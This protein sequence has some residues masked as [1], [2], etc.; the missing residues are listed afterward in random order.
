MNIKKFFSLMNFEAEL[1]STTTLVVTFIA[2][3]LWVFSTNYIGLSEN[4]GWFLV[5]I[6]GSIVFAISNI[7]IFGLYW[8]CRGVNRRGT[9]RSLIRGYKKFEVFI[10]NLVD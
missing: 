10:N 2:S 8:L 4:E 6:Q 1:L 7:I 3:M 9:Q 5:F